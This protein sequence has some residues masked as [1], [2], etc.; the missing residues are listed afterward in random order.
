MRAGV[1]GRSGVSCGAGGWCRTTGSYG[2]AGDVQ[3]A[4]V[5]RCETNTAPSSTTTSTG[6]STGKGPSGSTVMWRAR[7]ELF[8]TDDHQLFPALLAHESSAAQPCRPGAQDRAEG[9]AGSVDDGGV[10]SCAA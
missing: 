6:P 9:D 4:T 10:E 7:S 1:R 5:K 2:F 8:G 3:I